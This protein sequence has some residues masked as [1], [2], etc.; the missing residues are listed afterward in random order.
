MTGWHGWSQSPLH[1]RGFK[2]LER[3]GRIT[4]LLYQGGNA[5]NVVRALR[6]QLRKEEHSEFVGAVIFGL[7]RRFDLLYEV[8][9][10]GF[11]NGKHVT[12][13]TIGHWMHRKPERV[14]GWS[15]L[16]E[17][18]KKT[19][20]HVCVRIPTGTPSIWRTAND[21]Y[22][23]RVGGNYIGTY[24]SF[25]LAISAKALYRKHHPG[26]CLVLGKESLQGLA[27]APVHS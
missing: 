7:S 20:P 5:R 6:R 21:R 23:V 19:Y 13:L 18:R 25:S 1:V 15:V 17:E 26:R 14:I 10:G 22:R 27:N 16:P 4:A 11:R 24:D 12:F 8:G 2:T 3:G 9:D